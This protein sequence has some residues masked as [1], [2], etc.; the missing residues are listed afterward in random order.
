MMF[1]WKITLK[2]VNSIKCYNSYR[3]N[4]KIANQAVSVKETEKNI[5]INPEK[6][7]H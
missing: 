7:K 5:W 1:W 6:G 3:H 2:A 4:C